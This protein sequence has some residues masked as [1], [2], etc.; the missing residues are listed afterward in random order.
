L[1]SQQTGKII[2]PADEERGRYFPGKDA[3]LPPFSGQDAA[4][5]NFRKEEPRE[6]YPQTGR[7]QGGFSEQPILL[8]LRIGRS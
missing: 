3:L 4:V 7:H 5:V 2:D 6:Y 1:S 8:R